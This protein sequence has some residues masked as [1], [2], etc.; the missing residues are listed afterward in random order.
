MGRGFQSSDKLITAVDTCPQATSFHLGQFILV[1]I[2]PKAETL[3]HQAKYSGLS[4][5]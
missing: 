4:F 2:N 3:G 1:D 5:D